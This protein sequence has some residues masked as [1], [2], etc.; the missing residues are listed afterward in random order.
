MQVSAIG[1]GCMNIS[2]GYGVPP[3]V[4]QGEKVVLRPR[5]MPA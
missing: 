4:E 5:S 2:S 1:L 3:P